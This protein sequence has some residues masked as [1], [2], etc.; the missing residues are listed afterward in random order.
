[1]SKNYLLIYS[2]QLATDIELM[3][4]SIK[5]SS[6]TL[7]QIPKSS[8]SVYANIR[9]ATY[10]QSNYVLPSADY[11]IIPSLKLKPLE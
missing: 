6:N 5:A 4:Q 10:G 9:E 3:C 7:F 11:K 2:E 8:S 1:M